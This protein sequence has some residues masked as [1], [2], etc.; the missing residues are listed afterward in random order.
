MAP[1]QSIVTLRS[2]PLPG[3]APAAKATA[4]EPSMA[5]ATSSTLARS[6]SQTTGEAPVPWTSTACSGF[7]ISPTT[8]SPRAASNAVSRRAIWPC[9]PALTIF[10]LVCSFVCAR[11]GDLAACVLLVSAGRSIP[12]RVA[13]TRR[14]LPPTQSDRRRAGGQ[15]CSAWCRPRTGCSTTE[16]DRRV[17]LRGSASGSELTAESLG[18]PCSAPGSGE[19]NVRI[20]RTGPGRTHSRSPRALRVPLLA[21]PHFRHGAMLAR[22]SS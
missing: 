11:G 4:S 20:P 12:K 6:R 15:R 22:A 5:P 16:R 10:R 2:A 8:S 9:P 7:R 19:Q 21:V 3:P 1:S 13:R 17:P 14:P 18:P